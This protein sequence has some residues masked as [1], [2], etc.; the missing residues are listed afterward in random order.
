MKM[1]MFKGVCPV[2]AFCF[3]FFFRSLLVSRV[4]GVV[5]SCFGGVE[6]VEQ[7]NWKW[8]RTSKID[9]FKKKNNR[10]KENE[11]EE[12]THFLKAAKTHFINIIIIIIIVSTPRHRWGVCFFRREEREKKDG[13][14]QRET[15]TFTRGRGRG[16]VGVGV[17]REHVGAVSRAHLESHLL[18]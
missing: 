14:E 1:M 16:G 6:H 7:K 12:E 8:K 5:V 15:N 11:E 9:D 18:G 4:V 3:L 2:L 10:K 17:G 13:Y